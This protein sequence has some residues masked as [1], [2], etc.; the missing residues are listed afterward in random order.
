[1]GGS[2]HLLRG[3]VDALILKAVSAGPLH[4][5]GIADFVHETTRGV[6]DIE[7]GA[8]YRALHRL[9]QRGWLD[10]EW[11]ISEQGRR[12]KFYRLTAEGRRRL[13]AEQRDWER[14]AEAVGRVFAARRAGS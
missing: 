12:A 13:R 7:D 2:M 9:E 1:M 4:G 5:Y 8:L 11:G 14:Y 6:L 10:A 3:T